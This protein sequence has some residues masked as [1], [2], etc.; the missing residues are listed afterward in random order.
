MYVKFTR[1]YITGPSA[2]E[3]EKVVAWVGPY[4]PLVIE[5]EKRREGK[6]IARRT[7]TGDIVHE[8]GFESTENEYE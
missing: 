8:F 4:V 5:A 3:E 7:A 1:K 6:P 2:G